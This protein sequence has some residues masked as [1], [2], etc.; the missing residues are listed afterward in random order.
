MLQWVTKINKCHNNLQHA[1][2]REIT[3]PIISETQENEIIAEDSSPIYDQIYMSEQTRMTTNEQTVSKQEEEKE[4][5]EGDTYEEIVARPLPPPIRSFGKSTSTPLE[6]PS[7]LPIR[8]QPS[9]P[10]IPTEENG[11]TESLPSYDKIGTSD[12]G[13]DNLSDS[14]S[15]EEEEEEMYAEVIAPPQPPLALPDLATPSTPSAAST[16][17]TPLAPSTSSTPP[18]SLTPSIKP[19]VMTKPTLK[20]KI[21]VKLSKPFPNGYSSTKNILKSVKETSKQ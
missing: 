6:R 17:L 11:S 20:P 14:F 8:N 15:E 2:P 10:S 16:P 9:L 7:H 3:A 18:I 4:E 13:R 19:P 1:M 12:G 5:D 21:E